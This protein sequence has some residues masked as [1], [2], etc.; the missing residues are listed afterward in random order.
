MT[1]IFL[2]FLSTLIGLSA[3]AEENSVA[4]LTLSEAQCSDKALSNQALANSFVLL[5]ARGGNDGRGKSSCIKMSSLS[6][7][8]PHLVSG[9]GY[10]KSVLIENENDVQILNVKLL[11]DSIG[12]NYLVEYKVK[13]TK[14]V[15]AKGEFT[16]S[17]TYS[18]DSIE[19]VGC[20][21]IQEQPSINFLLE[22]CREEDQTL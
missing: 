17:R 13:N 18:K 5:I 9:D 14:G 16:Y 10:E 11:D 3:F 4:P 12:N 7:T 20:G 2:V 19:M 15:T 21:F 22:E 6:V 8:L 1:K